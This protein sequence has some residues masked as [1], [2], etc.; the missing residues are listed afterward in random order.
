MYQLRACIREFK[1]ITLL[2]NI[3]MYTG[4]H[5]DVAQESYLFDLFDIPLECRDTWLMYPCGFLWSEVLKCYIHILQSGEN[6]L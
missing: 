6:K 3:Q 4:V 2:G 1:E 5:S